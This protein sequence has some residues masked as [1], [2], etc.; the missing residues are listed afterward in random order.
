MVAAEAN[1][2][3]ASV[4]IAPGKLDG[5]PTQ[6]G[7]DLAA[8]IDLGQGERKTNELYDAIPHR[9]TNRFP[10]DV[11]KPVPSDFLETLSRAASDEPEVK[12]FLFTADP[13][14]KR[15]V[16]IIGQSVDEIL[17]FYPGMFKA[18]AK[19]FRDWNEAQ[20]TRDGITVDD[21]G[22]P[23]LATALL[24]FLPRSMD[25]M[26]SPLLI[27]ILYVDLMMTGR[28]HGAIAV[29]GRYEQSQNVSAGRI[30]QRAH[31]LATA[32]GLAA[33]PVNQAAELV[34]QEGLHDKEPKAA[35]TLATVTG[36]A[37]WQ[38]TFMFY[39]GY[40]THQ[41]HPTVRRSVQDVVI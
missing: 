2:Y 6:P 17:H 31:L 7:M 34:D 8:R 30:W 32:Y 33:R 11:R 12:L 28:L 35:A 29:R 26:M 21:V 19:W 22:Q 38:P 5:A 24:K 27:K 4:T 20:K 39:M 23:P 13:N 3:R 40:A 41:A 9:H 14:R 18:N 25:K 36:D 16:H 37:V 15:V 1:G 10:F